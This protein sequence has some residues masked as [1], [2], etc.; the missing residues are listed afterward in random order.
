[1]FLPVLG[2]FLFVILYIIAGILYPGGSE[3]DKTSIGFSFTNNY[4]CNLLYKNAINGQPNTGL[5]FAILAMFILIITL[6]TFW[7]LFP[8]KLGLERYHKLIIQLTGVAAMLIC[9][10]LLSGL[11]HDLVI[12]T[13]SILG[14]IATTGTIFALYKAKWFWFFMYGIFNVLLVVLNNYLY[15]AKGMMI[16]LPVVQ[17][18]SFLSFLVWICLINIKMYR[19]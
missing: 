9:F 13:A 7:F 5:P 18:L 6:S 14:L 4:W 19:L 12:N 16:Y 11:D 15:H 8:K 10:L 2:S 1:M 17:K 3:T